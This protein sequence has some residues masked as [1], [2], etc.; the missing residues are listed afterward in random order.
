MDLAYHFTDQTLRDGS[1][2]PPNGEWLEFT[3]D[4]IICQSGLHASRDPFDAL[5]YAPGTTLCRVEVDGIVGEQSDKL[6]AR[7]RR[8][9]ARADAAPMLRYFARMQALTC[10]DQW[11]APDIVCEWLMTGDESIKSAARDVAY[12]AACSAAQSA[13]YS[14]ARDAALS[15][16]ESAA[17]NAAYSAAWSAAYSAARYAAGA[18]ARGATGGAAGAAAWDAAREMFNLFV[19]E[20][21]WS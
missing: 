10:V 13:A 21:V 6:V 15:A 5:Q 4:V 12:S 19:S 8:I 2:I 7:R 17:R 9:I 11:A 20:L 1:P 18:A 3:G 16:V 14:A